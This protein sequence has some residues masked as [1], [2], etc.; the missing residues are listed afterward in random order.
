MTIG[1]TSVAGN[2]VISDGS[3]NTATI[4]VGALAGNYDYT[5]PV[6]TAND[7]FCLVTLANCSGVATV[8]T[9][10]TTNTSATGATISGSTIT[11]QDA[12][13]TAP[14]MVGTGAQTFAGNKTFTGELKVSKSSS[15]VSTALLQ[16]EQTG[17]GDTTIELKNAAGSSYYLG[18]DQSA[19]GLFRIGSSTSARVSNTVGT[20]VSGGSSIPNVS[21]QIIA[22]KVTTGPSVSGSLSSIAVYLSAVDGTNPGVKVGL[23]SHDSGNDRPNAL[24][25]GLD[26]SSTATVGW[27][28]LPISATISASTTYWIAINLEG[29]GSSVS[30]T[31]CGSCGGASASY[32]PMTYSNTWPS[33]LGAPN[34]TGDSEDYSFYMNVASGSVTDTFA[35]TKLF[36]ISDT[37]E[38][39]L[40]NS[41]NSGSA[42]EILNASGTSLFFA[43]TSS[44]RIRI[45][46]PVADAVGVVFVLDTK[47][48]AGDPTGVVGGMYYNSSLSKFRCYEG[49]SWRNCSTS[50]PVNIS[51]ATQAVTAGADTYLAGSVVPILGG[52]Q[53][54]TSG[55]QNG[56]MI[57]WKVTMSKT[58]AGTAA[59]TFTLRAGTNGTTADTARCTNFSTGTATA[60]ADWAEV[61]ITAYATAG[62]SAATLNCSGTLRHNLA[63]TGFSNAIGVQAYSTAASF[64]STPA[65][66]KMGLSFNA[67]TSSVIT[68]QKVEVS[69]TNL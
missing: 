13:A 12:S 7:T 45:G 30:Y 27:N 3:S 60:A 8:G 35:G 5:I 36:A 66:T 23:Y 9:Y 24:I 6:T 25:A 52:L 67:G 53:G 31:F 47:N 41:V 17:S 29:G 42:F 18:M 61:T 20:T 62:G 69:V 10:S 65:G 50:A 19:G 59:S 63:T 15:S 56:T 37:G 4:K 49:A 16:V 68:I 28:T 43:D 38:T 1:T 55:S 22:K 64:D 54:P 58:A 51:T 46:S 34:S 11:F 2:L 21:S 40:Q 33:T 44:S 26:A 32:Y 14:G 48:T 39:T 57:T